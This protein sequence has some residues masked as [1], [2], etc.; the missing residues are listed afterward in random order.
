MSTDVLPG[1]ITV[2]F[3]LTA[4]FFMPHTPA[5]AK[6]FTEEERVVALAR[7]HAD[8]HGATKEQDVNQEKFDW[9]WVKMAL[10]A[11]NTLFCSLAWFFLLIPLYVSALKA[12][13]ATADS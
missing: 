1:I 7:M 12:I 3:G 8:S 10:I 6:F 13:R 2:L 11:P 5:D 4:I 9:H